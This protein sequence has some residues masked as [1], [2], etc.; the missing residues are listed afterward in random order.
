[1]GWATHGFSGVVELL[2]LQTKIRLMEMGIG[3]GIEEIRAAIFPFIPPSPHGQTA[4]SFLVVEPCKGAQDFARARAR[5]CV[6]AKLS[7]IA[8]EPRNWN[9]TS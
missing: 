1:M 4:P 9:N 6:V 3:V 2:A 7:K 5:V 8:M